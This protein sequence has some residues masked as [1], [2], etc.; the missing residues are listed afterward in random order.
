ML[1]K[2]GDEL[3]SAAHQVFT[4]GSASFRTGITAKIAGIHWWYKE[5]CH[6]GELTAGY[7]NVYNYDGYMPIMQMLKKNG[8][9]ADF[10]CFEMLDSEQYGCDCSPEN[11]VRQCLTDSRNVGIGFGGENALEK[12]DTQHFNQIVKQASAVRKLDAFTFL[13][14]SYVILIQIA[15]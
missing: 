7:Y 2:H 5:D 10:T 4:N 9:S 14:L 12:F 3:M 15:L 1:I 8:A 13:R 11:L 6:A